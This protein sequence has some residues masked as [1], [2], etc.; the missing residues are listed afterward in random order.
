MRFIISFTTAASLVTIGFC[1]INASSTY[2]SGVN[3]AELQQQ[4][5][6]NQ[7]TELSKR[8]SGCT[9]QNVTVRKEWQGNSFS[10]LPGLQYRYDLDLTITHIG[11]L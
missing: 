4:A 9:L 3:L 7:L 6:R 2:T 5:Y 10:N 11:V 8:T 1:G